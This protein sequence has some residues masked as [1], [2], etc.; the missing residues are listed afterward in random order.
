LN[1]LV[2]TLTAV[3]LVIAGLQPQASAPPR[4]VRA[5]GGSAA[6]SGRVT[7]RDS[8]HPLPRIVVTLTAADPLKKGQTMTDEEGRYHFNGLEAGRYAISAAPDAHRSTYLGQQF[9]EPGPALPG[10]PPLRLR[11]ELK[12]GEAL[13]GVDMAL[14]RALAIEGRV[15]DAFDQPMTGVEVRASRADGSLYPVPPA[16]SD[17]QGAYRVFGLAPGRY[18]VCANV[19]SQSDASL[20]ETSS[21]VPTCHPAAVEAEA[22][23]VV[24]TSG[25]ALGIDIRVQRVGS[26]SVSGSVV[27]AAGALVD[28]AAVGAFPFVESGSS[29]FVTARDGEFVLK[30]LT[31]G[32]Y[33]IRASVGDR[34]PGNPREPGREPEV[35]YASAD[36]DVVDTTG[37]AVTLSRPVRVPGS[38]T[39]E[40]SQAPPGRGL[41]MAVH[42]RPPDDSRFRFEG[43]PPVSPVDDNLAFQLNG[44][45]RLP[46]VVGIQGLPDGWALSSVRYEGRD[47]T[48]VPTDFGS[49]PSPGRL[50]II[51]TSRVAHPSVRVTDEDG[52]PVISYHVLALPADPSRRLGLVTI[53]GSPSHDSVLKLGAMLPGEYFLAALPMAEYLRLMRDRTRIDAVA[54]VGT[55]VTL[56]ERD[57]RTFDLRL[58]T[59]PTP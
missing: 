3:L 18:R 24:L 49:G 39:F 44:L 6:I 47:I 15:L 5:A 27:D 20:T 9:G 43:P 50:A 14:S 8:G 37:I 55:R 13:P 23:D 19:R 46:V 52:T 11:V 2:E 1:A 32:R 7:E 30:G 40:G 22:S 34:Q 17:D 26:Y 21:L 45:Y 25:D 54:S 59:L 29:A 41:R 51:V 38:V 31:P 12:A 35:G 53:P 28:G 16:H 58:I 42:A 48:H 4:D 33:I 57:D 10:W 36:V 56:A